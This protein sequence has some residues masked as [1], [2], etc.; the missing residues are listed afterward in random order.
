MANE[1]KTTSRPPRRGL[2]LTGII[3]GALLVLLV[4]VY[5]VGTS[6]WALKS[7]ILPKVSKAMNGKVTVESASISPFSSV[8]M[9]GLKVETKGPDPLVTAREVRARYS[10]MDI[11]KGNMNVSEV[12]LESPVVT[13]VTFPDGTSNLDPLMKDRPP[14]RE[15]KP[16]AARDILGLPL[17]V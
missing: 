3:L 8:T 13:L 2:R 1:I 4:L 5:F 6:E 7:I 17:A 16:K 11:I 14:E 15:K 9:R 10:L 12:T